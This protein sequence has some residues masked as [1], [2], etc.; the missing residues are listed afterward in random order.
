MRMDERNSH[1]GRLQPHIDEVYIKKV[2]RDINHT[3]QREERN[4]N[5]SYNIKKILFQR[6]MLQGYIHVRALRPKI[7]Q[8]SLQPWRRESKKKLTFSSLP[9]CWW[10]NKEWSVIK[11]WRPPR[12]FGSKRTKKKCRR[13]EGNTNLF[14]KDIIKSEVSSNFEGLSGV[15]GN[16]EKYRG[17]KG[18]PEPVLGNV[19]IT[20]CWCRWR[21]W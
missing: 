20:K 19:G 1:L 14:P 21:S 16:K 17:K 18:T 12:G 11:F 4:K 9:P 2:I 10:H 13:V 15:L 7:K 5:N 6:I 3:L 8:S